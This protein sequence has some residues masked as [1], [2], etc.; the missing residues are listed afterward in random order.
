MRKLPF[1]LLCCFIILFSALPGKTWANH[2]A[3]GEI[4]YEC[5]DSATSQY[6][7]FFKFYRD[8]ALNAP[9]APTTMPLCYK[10]SCNTTIFSETMILYPGVIPPNNS[11]NGT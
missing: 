2:G 7:I 3:G 1:L 5:I 11:P 4:I 6:R 8:C 9:Q 10:S